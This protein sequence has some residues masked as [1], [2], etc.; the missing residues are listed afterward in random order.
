VPDNDASAFWIREWDAERDSARHPSRSYRRRIDSRVLWKKASSLISHAMFHSFRYGP[1]A[2]RKRGC[3]GTD[4][5]CPSN[6]RLDGCFVEATLDSETDYID[7]PS[8]GS[9]RRRSRET[10]ARRCCVFSRSRRGCHPYW[11]RWKRHIIRSRSR[12]WMDGFGR[13]RAFTGASARS[14]L[15]NSADA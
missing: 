2:H 14:A 12:G 13:Y 10:W 7:Q 6:A 4:V 1:L 11:K 5:A 9:R 3:P 8:I 15:E